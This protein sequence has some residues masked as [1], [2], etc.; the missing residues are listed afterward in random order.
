MTEYNGNIGFLFSKLF[1]QDFTPP[2]EDEPEKVV[3]EN[4]KTFTEKLQN[5]TLSSYSP[6]L[7]K[8]VYQHFDLVTTYPGL[9]IGSG[10]SHEVH[11]KDG[12]KLGFYFDHTTGLP[13]IPG[14]SVKGVLNW[15]E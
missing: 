9:L 4:L 7:E 3:F 11:G 10:Y 13:I 14:S 2:T 8:I 6:N 12:L 15:R 1:F 5:Q